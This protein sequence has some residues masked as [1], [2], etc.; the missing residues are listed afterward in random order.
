MEG[1]D[2]LCW[3]LSNGISFEVK[4]FYKVL[5]PNVDSLVS[6]K[7]I[8]RTKAPLKWAFFIWT[9]YVGKILTLDNLCKRH[10]IMIE[11]CCTC[12]KSGK[13]LNHLFFIVMLLE[14]CGIWFCRCLG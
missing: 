4:S 8:W 11:W 13:T 10:I 1:D 12:K 6:W 5:L 14:S 9:A 2:R 7:S 3:T